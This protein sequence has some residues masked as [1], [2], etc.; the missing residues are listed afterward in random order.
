MKAMQIKKSVKIEAL[1]AQNPKGHY[2][3][4]W[5]EGKGD[6]AAAEKSAQQ[7]ILT[8]KEIAKSDAFKEETRRR[9]NE[10]LPL[11]THVRV[12]AG[13]LET[14]DEEA[15]IAAWQLERYMLRTWNYDTVEARK[16]L[17]H[18]WVKVAEKKAAPKEEA[19]PAT[20]AK[21]PAKKATTARKTKAAAPKKTAAASN[22]DQLAAKLADLQAQLS[23]LASLIGGAK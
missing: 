16:T 4:K 22:E 23:A 21:A 13:K 3:A 18:P 9:A 6:K 10:L 2:T 17:K 5:W 20:K 12:L 15:R 7:V 11:A 8:C 1:L 14:T 19:K